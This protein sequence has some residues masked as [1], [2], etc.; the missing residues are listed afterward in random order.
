VSLPVIPVKAHPAIILQAQCL[1]LLQW[2]PF[3]VALLIVLLV[4]YLYDVRVGAGP[5]EVP[6]ALLCTLY[7]TATRGARYFAP[8][9][10]L[11]KGHAVGGST[12]FLHTQAPAFAR[13]LKFYSHRHALPRYP[14]LLAP[15]RSE[16]NCSCRNHSRPRGTRPP[17]WLC[18]E[19]NQSG[20][21]Y[22]HHIV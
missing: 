19:K 1:K 16:A 12:G 9:L 18:Q 7:Q 2:Q 8:P 14:G 15:P 20:Q 22:A 3:A 6:T 13:G 10:N 21:G 4:I 5:T 17:P 11:D